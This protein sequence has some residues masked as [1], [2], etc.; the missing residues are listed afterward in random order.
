[1]CKATRL[2]NGYLAIKDDRDSWGMCTTCTECKTVITA[3][4]MVMSGMDPRMISRTR[5]GL[6]ESG[7]VS[8]VNY[9]DPPQWTLRCDR[10]LALR[11]WS[12]LRYLE[13]FGRVITIACCKLKPPCQ[14]P[15]FKL[16]YHIFPALV[17]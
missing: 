15:L 8:L 9:V 6:V 2:Y 17:E 5:V 4:L 7:L 10:G 13:A 11:R 14:P 12:L 16:S 1:V 3:M